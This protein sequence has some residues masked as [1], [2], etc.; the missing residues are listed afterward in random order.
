MTKIFFYINLRPWTIIAAFALLTLAGCD[1]NPLGTVESQGHPPVVSSVQI[2]PNA[3]FIDSISPANGLYTITEI[4]SA[5]VADADGQS[6]IRSVQ[7]DIVGPSGE[8][9]F[10]VTLLD[11]GAAPDSIRGDGIYTAR[12]TFNV[13]RAMVGRY[14]P[15][16]TATDGTG[17]ASSAV[18]SSF[19]LYRRNSPPSLSNLNAPDTVH[20]QVGVP[21]LIP[22]TVVASDSDGLDD[23]KEVFFLSLDSSDP[24]AR[25]QLLDDGGANGS[26]SGD[27]LAGDGVFSIIIRLTPTQGMKT[28]FRFQFQAQDAAGDTSASILHTLNIAG[29]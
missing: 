22:M 17:L 24:T 18:A 12:V 4:L 3:V 20:A 21:L 27:Q 9:L 19:L 28:R 8:H 13:S 23:I 2:N 10:N 16:V 1:K 5:K 7:G 25:F 6:D 26:L 29:L 14:Y 15:F 11:N